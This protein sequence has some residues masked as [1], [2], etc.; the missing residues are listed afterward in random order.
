MYLQTG[1]NYDLQLLFFLINTNGQ[2][3]Q[4]AIVSEEINSLACAGKTK[5]SIYLFIYFYHSTLHLVSFLNYPADGDRDNNIKS[6]ISEDEHL[7]ATDLQSMLAQQCLSM[8]CV[9]IWIIST[10][11]YVYNYVDG[12][13]SPQ[14]SLAL[15]AGCRYYRTRFLVSHFFTLRE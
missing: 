12:L 4:I 14:C 1:K 2:S 9:T 10:R 7:Q 8:L 5:Q 6:T 13:T 15:C 3:W 11:R